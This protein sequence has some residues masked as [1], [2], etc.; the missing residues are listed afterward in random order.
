METSEN[1]TPVVKK[2]SKNHYETLNEKIT[3]MKVT[4]DNAMLPQIFAVM[5][6]VGYTAERI[7]GMNAKLEELILL[8]ANQI[9]ESADETAAQ[10]LFN[11]KRAEINKVFNTHRGL[12]RILFKEDALARPTLQLDGENPV[13]YGNWNQLVTQV[14]AQLSTPGMLAQ[15]STI[16]ITQ[17]AVTAQQQ[18]MTELYALKDSIIKEG[19]EAE[20]ATNVRDCAFDELYPQYSDYIKYA[21]LLMPNDQLLEMIGV[22]VR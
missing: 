1:A 13:A 3:K 12:L 21:K 9:K 17:E 7:A 4:F 15:T 5:V 14:Y 19:G 16:G 18:A 20:K 8:N 6:T 11:A 2:T 22:T 10:S